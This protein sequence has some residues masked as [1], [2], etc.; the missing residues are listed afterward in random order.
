MIWYR[1]YFFLTFSCTRHFIQFSGCVCAS[2]FFL[3]VY[4]ILFL[5]SLKVYE[6][7]FGS[8]RVYEFFGTSMLAGYLKKKNLPPR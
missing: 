7:F 2:Y 5:A 8:V 3:R 4:L 1:H 6:I